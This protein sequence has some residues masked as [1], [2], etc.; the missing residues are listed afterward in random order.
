[1]DARSR[2]RDGCPSAEILRETVKRGY[3]GFVFLTDASV[4]VSYVFGKAG[5]NDSVVLGQSKDRVVVATSS[6]DAAEIVNDVKL[7]EGTVTVT[8]KGTGDESN[9]D[10]ISVLDE[11]N[12]PAC[13][14]HNDHCHHTFH[15]PGLCMVLSPY[16]RFAKV[17]VVYEGLTVVHGNHDVRGR[18][19]R[20]SLNLRLCK[21]L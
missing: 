19:R 2:I 6:Y 5:E 3:E 12:Y 20:F 8:A 11:E 7:E 4:S 15:L 17:S 16:G 13:K 10:H 18:G 1:M 21:V 14:G 9:R